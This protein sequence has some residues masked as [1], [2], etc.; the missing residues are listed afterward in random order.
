MPPGPSMYHPLTSLNRWTASRCANAIFSVVGGAPSRILCL[1]R[2]LRF[3]AC[4]SKRS[5][6]SSRSWMHPRKIAG[7]EQSFGLLEIL[8]RHVGSIDE[9]CWHHAIR[10]LGLSSLSAGLFP[11]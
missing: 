11:H 10:T 8:S 5:A 7:S 3:E 9:T 1:T 4:L 6:L 2:F